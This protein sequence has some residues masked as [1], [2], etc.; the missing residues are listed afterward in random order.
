[1]NSN[2]AFNLEEYLEKNLPLNEVYLRHVEKG[3]KFDPIILSPPQLEKKPRFLDFNHTTYEYLH[4]FESIWDSSL[5][6]A[7]RTGDPD[8]KI[9]ANLMS[10]LVLLAR[11]SRLHYYTRIKVIIQNFKWANVYDEDNYKLLNLIPFTRI[12]C[13][14]EKSKVI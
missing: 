8:L 13:F 9:F 5:L 7:G 12:F 6:E 4:T 11:E 1:M 2:K 14:D 10:S 3:D